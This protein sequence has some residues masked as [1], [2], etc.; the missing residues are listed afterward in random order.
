MC[1]C[2]ETE[3][4]ILFRNGDHITCLKSTLRN[5]PR[6]V[7]RLQLYARLMKYLKPSEK[8]MEDMTPASSLNIDMGA[9]ASHSWNAR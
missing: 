5:S 7:S 8:N 2:F 6:A 4:Q 9:Y 1:S 3:P